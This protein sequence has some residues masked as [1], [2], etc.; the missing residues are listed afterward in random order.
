MV[1][2][3]MGWCFFEVGLICVKIVKNDLVDSKTTYSLSLT[4][5]QLVFDFDVVQ[6]LFSIFSVRAR[7]HLVD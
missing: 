1:A 2:S 3:Y 7:R 4:L 5:K 6:P